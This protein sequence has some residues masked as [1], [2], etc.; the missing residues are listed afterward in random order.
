MKSSLTFTTIRMPSA[1]MNGCS[2]LPAITDY[3]GQPG[4][5]YGASDLGYDEGLFIGFGRV[6]SMFPYRE[7][8]LYSRELYDTDVRVVILENDY[9]KATFYPDMGGKLA[10]LYD[11]KG[12][13]ELLVFNPV[14][15]PCN[16]ALLNAWTSGGIEYNC[17]PFG[18]HPL[19]CSTLHTAETHLDDGTPVL[20]FYE[21]ERK[22]K[23]VYQM[24]FFLPSDSKMLFARMRY[25]NPNTHVIPA[26]WWSN[27]AVPEVDGGRTI[28]PADSAYTPN[29]K[30][31]ITLV[32]VPEYGGVDVT[33]PAKNPV[34]V[35][36]FFKIPD[37]ERKYEAEIG[38]DGKGFVQVSTSRLIGRKQ[39]VWGQ[40]PGGARW[41]QFL[42]SDDNKEKYTEIQAGLAHS[43]YEHLPMPPRTA[44]EWLEGYGAI[45]TDPEKVH[46]DWHTS[47]LETEE[48]LNAIISDGEMEK[49]LEE[50]KPMAL[51]PA[52]KVLT[53]GSGW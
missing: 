36:Y 9:L 29:E 16:L 42:T 11:K 6:A 38:P 13:R 22:R 52:E 27:M 40:G 39:F 8:D 25:V 15:R 45:D 14:I 48:K 10:G 5:E 41:Q 47:R 30:G 2:S 23:I 26:Y 51:S 24:D 33:Y 17:G 35:D 49:L 1:K 3:R 37:R 31:L 4:T 19:T 44:W 43:Q 18:H 21:F 20:R 34:A 50:T 12:K 28:V 7:Q 53:H 32:P 46:S